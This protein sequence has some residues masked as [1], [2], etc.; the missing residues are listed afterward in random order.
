MCEAIPVAQLATIRG[1]IVVEYDITPEV[2]QGS[3][4]A[5][6]PAGWSLSQ[7]CEY[8]MPSFVQEDIK[9]SR[10]NAPANPSFCFLLFMLFKI[11]CNQIYSNF[12]YLPLSLPCGE[13][14]RGLFFKWF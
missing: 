3:K 9:I 12:L 7:L 8:Q 11:I 13:V 4:D 2:S 5:L 6:C 14:R 1:C 10:K